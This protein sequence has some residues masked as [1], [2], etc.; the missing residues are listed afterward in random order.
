MDENELEQMAEQLDEDA[1]L[2]EELRFNIIPHALKYFVGEGSS[3]E[4]DSDDSDDDSD[5]DMPVPSSG[6]SGNPSGAPE[7]QPECKQQ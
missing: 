3:D 4:E 1:E 6:A 5:D 7:D 2:G